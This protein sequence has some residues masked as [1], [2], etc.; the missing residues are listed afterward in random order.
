METI[1]T[2]ERDDHSWGRGWVRR[3]SILMESSGVCGFWLLW[4][5]LKIE[6]NDGDE[7]AATTLMAA[8]MHDDLCWIVV[9]WWR[10]WKMVVVVVVRP[11]MAVTVF[12]R[13]GLW[14]INNVGF[15]DVNAHVKNATQKVDSIQK[16]LDNIG[17]V[18]DLF[19][20]A[21]SGPA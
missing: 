4:L 10:W 12:C 21:L 3:W 8:A 18:D 14:G 11:K 2:R 19:I 5:G 7:I 6:E 20:R 1:K 17:V 9:W 15:G 13:F 16:H